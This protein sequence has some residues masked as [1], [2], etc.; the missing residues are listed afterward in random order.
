[1]ISTPMW[2][3][4]VFIIHYKEIRGL[5]DRDNTIA[6]LVSAYYEILSF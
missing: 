2:Q 3:N 6:L 1:M 4:C 5:Y